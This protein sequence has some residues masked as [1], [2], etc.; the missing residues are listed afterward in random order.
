MPEPAE[1]SFWSYARKALVALLVGMVAAGGTIT[2]AVA[3]DRLTLSEWWAIG[4][5]VAAAIVGPAAVYATRNATRAAA[6][7]AVRSV[8]PLP[9]GS[10][11]ANLTEPAA[12]RAVVRAHIDGTIDLAWPDGDSDRAVVSRRL[13]EAM[14]QQH[15][16]LT[17]ALGQTSG[18]KV[19][20]QWTPP[21]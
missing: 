16:K 20:R 5:A 7:S 14:V 3:D 19:P 13:L 9:E 4:L 15:N 2:A 21:S 8:G 6:A 1:P 12:P 18:P 17:T 10:P 11:W